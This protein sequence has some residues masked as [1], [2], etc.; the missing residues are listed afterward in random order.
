MNVFNLYRL[1]RRDEII[2]HR[3]RIGHSYITHD[4]LLRGE[5][6]PRCSACDVDLAVEHI[7]LHCVSFATARDNSF[8]MTVTTLLELFTKVSSRSTIE[9]IKTTGLYRKI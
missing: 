2:I 6:C 7:L 1:P 9:F 3:L 5:T 4:H 8:N